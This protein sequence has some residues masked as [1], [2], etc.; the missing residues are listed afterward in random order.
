MEFTAP[1]GGVIKYRWHKN[2]ASDKT[3]VLLIGTIGN[4]D[5]FWK[6]FGILAE[7]YSVLTFDY[8]E[9]IEHNNQ[10]ADCIAQLIR[11]LGGK[12]W[13]LGQ[14]L[15]GF[16]AQIIAQR[17]PGIVEGLVL[18]NTACLA[19][20]MKPAAVLALNDLIAAQSINQ[21]L[22]SIAPMDII[23]KK[24]LTVD[25][26]LYESF[27]DSQKEHSDAFS[28]LT[29]QTLTRGRIKH[30]LTMLVDLPKQFGMVP[31]EFAYLEGRVLLLLSPD[32]TMFSED[33]RD[34]LIELMPSPAVDRSLT[35]GHLAMFLEPEEYAAKVSE[36]IES[37]PLREGESR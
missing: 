32:D 36:F 23:K 29:E 28:E 24:L 5:A 34:E 22:V 19:K 30:S 20:D 15:G 31:D 16:M 4:S 26:K 6:H 14:S 17:H 9:E 2:P 37:A 3:L 27:T 35:G 7:K 18:S 33:C 25:T 10:I 1:A 8:P 13:L 11:S 21:K 12:V